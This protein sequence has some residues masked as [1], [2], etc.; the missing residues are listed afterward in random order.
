MSGNHLLVQSLLDAGRP[1]GVPLASSMQKA[2]VASC[3]RPKLTAC[4]FHIQAVRAILSQHRK[5]IQGCDMPAPRPFCVMGCEELQ[6]SFSLLNTQHQLH[7]EQGKPSTLH[8][9]FV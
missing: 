3:H 1:V 6:A 2:G 5:P 8:P 9:V 7:D 4:V